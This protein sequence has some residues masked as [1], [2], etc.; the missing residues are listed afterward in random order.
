[1]ISV[2][3]NLIFGIGANSSFIYQQIV[4]ASVLYIAKL[5]N[6]MSALCDSLNSLAGVNTL[7]REQVAS[8]PGPFEIRM[9]LGAR[10]EN[11]LLCLHV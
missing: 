5:T 8:H 10:L 7:A 6:L 2:F 9:G 4:V 3:A 11:K 1:M